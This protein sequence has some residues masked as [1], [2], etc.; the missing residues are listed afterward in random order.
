M[1]SPI[2]QH[3]SVVLVSPSPIDPQSIRSE[4]LTSAQIV[5]PGWALG[6]QVNSPVFALTQYKNGVSIQTQGN[7]CV[8]QEAIAGP[9]RPEYEI[10]GLARR[11]VEATK[12]V[13]YNALGI[14]WLLHIAVDNPTEWL[15]DQMGGGGNFPGF[16]PTSL[17]MAKPMAGA[18]CNLVFRGQQETV[19][20]DC[21]YHFQLSSS[22]QPLAALDHW[23]QCQNALTE[24]VFPA[25]PN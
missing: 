9:L 16:S 18:V 2:V 12:L 3:A 20:V 1:P 15:R 22:L 19:V 11:Y 23:H 13:P 6:N 24:G 7:H 4:A 10:H 21:N 8:F 17:Q 14:N 5:P 25:L